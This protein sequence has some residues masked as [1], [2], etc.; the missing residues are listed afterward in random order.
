MAV[1]LHQIYRWYKMLT[2][3]SVWHVNQDIGKFYSSVKLCG[4]YNN[5]TE[6]VTRMPDYLDSEELPQLNLAGGKFVYFPVAIFQYGLGCYDLYLQTSE[7]KYLKKFLQCANWAYEHLDKQGRWNNFFYVYPNNP[8]GA[9]AQGEGVSLMLR[10]YVETQDERFYIASKQAIDFML[11]PIEKGGTTIYKND[12]VIFMEYTHLPVVMNGWIFSWWG[13]YDYI[14]VSG[15][16]GYYK[17][18]LNESLTTLMQMLPEF[19]CFYWSKYDLGGKL[20]SPFYHN[21]HIAQMQAM[22]TLTKQNLFKEYAE[23][24]T[25][26]QNN[27]ALKVFAFLHKTFQKLLEK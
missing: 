1:N 10:A 16:H 20:A 3:Q 21:L 13:L 12:K 9:M 22:F 26:Q 6:K 14:L 4:Y 25:K 11:S 5:L 15:D 17:S 2:G 23:L 24:W 27:I 19:K 18:L 7:E 8:Y